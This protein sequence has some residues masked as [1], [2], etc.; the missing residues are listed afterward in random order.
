M[1][2]RLESLGAYLPEHVISLREY[3][4]R[5]TNPPAFDLEAVTGIRSL[6]LAG[7]AEDC[8]Q[9]GLKAASD[10]LARS[11]YKA[12]DIDVVISAAT[13]RS[14]QGENL[15][16]LWEPSLSLLF[17]QR[18]GATKAQHF[19]LAN[20]GASMM[21]AV[22]LLEAMIK[23]GRVRNGLIISAEHITQFG[24]TAQKE[25]SGANDPQ[26]PSMTF[27]DSAAA[28]V[29]DRSEAD[30]DA[31]HYCKLMTTAEFAQLSIGLP[32]DKSPGLALYTLNAEV[33]KRDQILLWAQLLQDYLRKELKVLGVE[34]FDHIIH[35]QIA[36]R[37]AEKANV[38]AADV[39]GR[40]LPPALGIVEQAGNVGSTAHFLVLHEALRSGKVQRG[41]KILMVPFASGLVSGFLSLSTQNVGL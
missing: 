19:D 2:A 27:G 13:T 6:H 4:S 31:I 38:C 12:A 21:T 41:D 8:L 14:I 25:I 28:I 34:K 35:Q 20:A 39:L 9:M 18:L 16:H 37:F 5:M 26:F 24:E 15:E 17:K 3:V 32:S 29:L 30:E 36:L 22:L 23:S 1:K 7:S 10:A 11:R 40:V 33:N